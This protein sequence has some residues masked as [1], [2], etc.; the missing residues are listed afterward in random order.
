MVKYPPGQRPSGSTT[1]AGERFLNYWWFLWRSW[2]LYSYKSSWIIDDFSEDSSQGFSL[3]GFPH[4]RLS[5]PFWTHK[6]QKGN[7]F[8]KNVFLIW[9]SDVEYFFQMW[10]GGLDKAT[11]DLYDL[12]GWWLG[13]YLD[14]IIYNLQF[15]EISPSYLNVKV[16]AKLPKTKKLFPL[17]CSLVLVVLC[18]CEKEQNRQKD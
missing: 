4:Y 16:K 5:H 3:P 6:E 7:K 8:S 10:G 12:K 14:Y 11:Q 2:R 9:R 15:A 13:D 17:E 18:G 1:R